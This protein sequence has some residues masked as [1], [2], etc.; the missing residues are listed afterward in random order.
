MGAKRVGA[1]SP[2]GETG[3][4]QRYVF[5]QARKN[6]IKLIT[7]K[8][9]LTGSLGLNIAHYIVDRNWRPVDKDDHKLNK[10]ESSNI[11]VNLRVT[12]QTT[13]KSTL[14]V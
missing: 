13:A 4:I 5:H 6:V 2:W 11:N 1:N 3:I 7:K 9:H 8:H 12:T 14:V 10:M